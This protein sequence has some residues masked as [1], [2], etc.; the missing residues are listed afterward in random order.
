[1][2]AAVSAAG[3]P[4]I[5]NSLSTSLA[6]V[7]TYANYVNGTNVIGGE[8]EEC[9]MNN[10]W[11]GE[12][13][14]QIDVIANLKRAGKAPGAG[15]WC[16]LD[17]TN[18]DGATA[19][20][21]RLFSYASFLLTYDPNYSVFQESFT[22]PS[23]FQVFPETGF[24]PLQPASAPS[25][26]TSLQIAGGAYVQ[27]YGAC[28]YRGAALG[29]CEVAV[30][31]GSSTVPLP[32]SYT[33]SMVI[34]GDGVLDGGSVTFTGAPVTQL[35]PKSGA[36]LVAP[37]TPQPAP[38]PA[39]TTTPAS[40]PAPTAAPAAAALSGTVSYATYFASS[41]QF[42]VKTA[43]GYTWVCTNSGTTWSGASLAVGDAVAV[44]AGAS[45]SSCA[46]AASILLAAP[47]SPMIS[48]TVTYSKYYSTSGGFQITTPSG[49]QLWVYDSAPYNRP[50]AAGA[51]VTAI[52]SYNS[53]GNLL[54]SGL[55]VQ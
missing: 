39:A 19:I 4:V 50:I 3:Q 34:S 6:N 16:Y 48:G 43:S 13:Q 20:P 26:Y 23:T 24:V 33:H 18:A 21:Q 15:F 8:W 27:T 29:P 45:T 46:V 14:S 7:Q 49:T 35:A 10:T 1:M 2:D 17:N 11:A 52:G 22:T 5:V 51:T 36:I 9:F 37:A 54:A 32:N 42:Q 55:I 41:G 12:E 53:A 47:G 40:T 31:P 28:Y 38:T 44:S 30:N 25:S